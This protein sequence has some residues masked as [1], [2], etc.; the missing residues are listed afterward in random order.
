[1]Q[2]AYDHSSVSA[3]MD[4]ESHIRSLVRHQDS[5]DDIVAKLREA[6]H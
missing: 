4:T 2:Y 3:I 6:M 1:M 5:I